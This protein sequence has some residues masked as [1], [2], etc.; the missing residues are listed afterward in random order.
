MQRDAKDHGRVRVRD[1]RKGLAEL[2]D[3]L[4]RQPPQEGLDVP[5]GFGFADRERRV[6]PVVDVLPFA[7]DL[8][9]SLDGEER[10]DGPEVESCS[11]IV[12]E[13]GDGGY[14]VAP[15][16]VEPIGP[17]RVIGGVGLMGRTLPWNISGKPSD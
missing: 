4:G 15:E 6:A 7:V 2:L 1:A 5:L 3:V 8:E 12:L 11:R 13:E 9:A 14:E 10:Q 16:E 17:A